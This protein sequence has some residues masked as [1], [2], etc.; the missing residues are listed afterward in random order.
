MKPL[1]LI[2]LCIFR[3]NCSV[4]YVAARSPRK[5]KNDSYTI[6]ARAI[7]SRLNEQSD[8]SEK[9]HSTNYDVS[10]TSSALRSLS[11]AQA[12]LKKIDGTA[13]EMYQRTHKSSTN[14]ADDDVGEDIG[15]EGNKVGSLKVAGRM[16][17]KAARVGCIA[18]ALFTAELCELVQ[19]APPSVESSNR[20]VSEVKN[21]FLYSDDG[22]LASWTERKVVFNSTIHASSNSH[23]TLQYP[24]ISVIV[25]Y[26]PGY[27]GGAGPSHG[28][29]DDLL[30]FSKEDLIENQ[31]DQEES[32][33]S[34]EGRPR[35]RGRYLVILSDNASST[36]TSLLDLSSTVS[37]LDGPPYKL[38]LRQQS[39]SK[40]EVG[41]CEP[42]YHL[43]GQLVDAIEPILVEGSRQPD[44]AT[45][46]ESDPETNGAEAN[47]TKQMEPAIHVVGHS[48]AGGVAA[49]AALLL[50]GVL[51][52][53]ETMARTQ[54]LQCATKKK[55]NDN[56]DLVNAA[57]PREPIARGRS[58]AFCLG[59]PPCLSPNL[60]AP[61][62]TSIIHGDDIICRTSHATL[63]RL[64]ERTRHSIKGGV[65]GRSVGW[66][67]DALSLTVSGLKS[68]SKKSERDRL[69]VPGKVFLIRPRRIGGGSS[70]I[71]EVGDTAAGGRE[72]FRAAV[73]WQLNDI[74]LSGSMLVHHDLGAYIRSLD[75]VK[76]SGL[77]D[78]SVVDETSEI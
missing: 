40:E 37:I 54:N 33:E 53:P 22:A 51:P 44:N 13:H 17:R 43:A 46:F 20:D 71:H 8:S 10:T 4:Q 39:I 19:L 23:G 45:D 78:E 7:Q 41:V 24:S 21:D 9:T 67:T 77:A 12:A 74:L 56:R 64:C 76:L 28:G 55:H 65:L 73:L 59:P 34:K 47:V 16:S 35:P 72:T 18:D 58:S 42:L 63:K 60:R 5:V 69:V 49:L 50:D 2:I 1:P 15:K 48:L 75:R 27:S 68:Q 11:T 29:V 3:L 14:L 36:A 61:F 57:V 38:K 62:I 6:L 25:I 66:M 26:E 70:S 32:Y 52:H 30:Q 31:D